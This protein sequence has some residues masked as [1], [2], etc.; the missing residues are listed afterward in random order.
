VIAVSDSGIGIPAAD[1]P[2]IFE[3]FHRAANAA[4]QIH[5]TGLGLASVQRIVEQHGGSIMVRSVEGEGS[6]FTLRLPLG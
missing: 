6:T 4:G 5:G 2:R 1:L 3:R